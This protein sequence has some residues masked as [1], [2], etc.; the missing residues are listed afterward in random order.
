MFVDSDRVSDSSQ[1]YYLKAID[2]S[3]NTS[4]RTGYVEGVTVDTGDTTRPVKPT[5]LAIGNETGTSVELTWSPS[6]DD[7]EVVGYEVYRADTD[8][9]TA[10]RIAIAGDTLPESLTDLVIADNYDSYG[11][12]AQAP[13][14][15]T[16]GLGYRGELHIGGLIHLRNRD[17]NPQTRTFTT[18][19]PLPGVPGTTT[20]N[21]PYHYTNNNPTNLTD[22]TGLR[23]NDQ[24]L[25]N[26][27]N[28]VRTGLPASSSS[29]SGF[30]D[31]LIPN[32]RT[33]SG[34]AN[35]LFGT[36][37]ALQGA[38]TQL[39]RFDG[40]SIIYET[41][42]GVTKYRPLSAGRTRSI[43]NSILGPNAKVA[44]QR[45]RY[46]RYAGRGLVVAG[47]AIDAVDSYQKYDHLDTRSRVA[48]SAARTTVSLGG[49]VAGAAGG[50][51]I[52]GSAGLLC[53]PAAVI[54]TPVGAGVGTVVGGVVGAGLAKYG[55]D[56]PTGRWF[57]G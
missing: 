7:V 2:S 26:I 29:G 6:T 24:N 32:P 31:Y 28:R 51:S 56:K 5:G 36:G 10:E 47:V 21:N 57:G 16:F 23:P 12:P 42:T 18:P 40:R 44:V 49:A 43:R 27:P 50:A 53:G 17:Y 55:W 15:D 45:L 52:G 41:K 48:A 20:N 37:S 30:F 25:A 19:D 4:W 13:Q 1:W 46:A 3:G 54:C 35:T 9:G 38:F 39:S 22:P 14:P 8:L 34:G 11:N 33:W